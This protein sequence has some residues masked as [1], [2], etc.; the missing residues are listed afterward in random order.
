[1]RNKIW[2]LSLIFSLIGFILIEKVFTMSPNVISGNGNVAILLIPLLSPIFILSIILTY[3]KVREIF[4]SVKNKKFTFIFLMISAIFSVLLIYLIIH[5]TNDL[6]SAL[7]GTPDNPQSKIYR[8]GWW[9]QYT[10]SLFFN[11]YTYL[12]IHLLSGMIGVFTIFKK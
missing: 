6:I 5:Y 8:F 3:K 7:G 1:M 4:G 2:I 9:N 10:N 11:V 12:L